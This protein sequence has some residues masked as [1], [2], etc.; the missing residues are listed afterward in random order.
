MTGDRLVMLKEGSIVAD[1][2]Y[3]DLAASDDEWIK[4]F[5]YKILKTKQ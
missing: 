4:S 2:S 3:D 1:G 5:L